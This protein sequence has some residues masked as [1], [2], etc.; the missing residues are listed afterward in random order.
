MGVFGLAGDDHAA[1]DAGA[2]LADVAIIGGLCGGRRFGRLGRLGGRGLGRTR[3]AGHIDHGFCPVLFAVHVTPPHLLG[4][5]VDGAVDLGVVA[6]AA[7]VPGEGLLD[8][9][10]GRVRV[11]LE[12]SGGGHQEAGRAEAALVA[13][14]LD[15]GLLDGV[16]LVPVRQAFDRLDRPAVGADGQIHAGVDRLAVEMDGAAAALPRSQTFLAPVRSSLSRRTSRRVSLA[17]TS[18]VVFRP[19]TASE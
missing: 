18:S 15:E 8:L 9:V 14:L 12:E 13:V 4:R 10:E 19:L 5:E 2:R 17:S 1:V 11:L 3:L 16:E 6:A 7:E